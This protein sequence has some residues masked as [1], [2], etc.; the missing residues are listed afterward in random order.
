MR[1]QIGFDAALPAAGVLITLVNENLVVGK[2]HVIDGHPSVPELNDAV[3]TVGQTFTDSAN[4]VAVTVTSKNGNSY[5]VTVNRG[6]VQPPPQPQ[7]QNQTTQFIQLAITGINSQPAVIINPNTTVTISIQ[8]SNVGTMA[9][10][11]V[12]I[13]VTLDGTDGRGGATRV[14]AAVG[15]DPELVGQGGQDARLVLGLGGQQSGMP[16]AVDRQHRPQLGCDVQPVQAQVVGGPAGA[17]AG[18]QVAVAGPVDLLDPGPQPGDG[19]P[20][21]RR[22]RASTMPVLARGGNRRRPG[23]SGWVR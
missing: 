2:V 20:A 13:Q 15:L 22:P 16:V 4:N 17:E 18:G 7:N 21:R 9:A 12:P 3:W 23:R 1:A 19:F 14:A 10:A 8:I 5:E 6:G 11:N